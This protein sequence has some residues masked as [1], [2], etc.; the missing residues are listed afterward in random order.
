[1]RTRLKSLLIGSTIALVMIGSGTAAFMHQ[2]ATAVHWA[3]EYSPP[4]FVDNCPAN[5]YCDAL[6]EDLLAVSGDERS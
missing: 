4:G 2:R 5:M 6:F 1:M 3:S